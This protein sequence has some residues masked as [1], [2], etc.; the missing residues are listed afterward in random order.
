M[1]NHQISPE[2]QLFWG[3]VVATF[4]LISLVTQL[5][6]HLVRDPKKK[7]IISLVASVITGVLIFGLVG[8]VSHWS[9]FALLITIGVFW[10]CRVFN[11]HE[12]KLRSDLEA[13]GKT[14]IL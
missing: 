2:A 8:L 12:P 7:R 9:I 14:K 10:L 5:C 3:G 11:K 6:I 1:H 13:L 4:L